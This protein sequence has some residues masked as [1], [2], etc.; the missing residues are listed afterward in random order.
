M[1]GASGVARTAWPPW[2]QAFLNWIAGI[3]HIVTVWLAPVLDPLARFG[4][5]YNLPLGAVFAGLVFGILV[6]LGV[7]WFAERPTT[8]GPGTVRM[9]A[10]WPWEETPAA[11]PAGPATGP[12]AVVKV[13]RKEGVIEIPMSGAGEAPSLPLPRARGFVLVLVGAFAA[14]A[15]LLLYYYGQIF[16]H[17]DHLVALAGTFLYWPLRW[18]G[19]Y[20]V[21]ANALDVPDY[22]FPMYLAAMIAFVAASGLLFGRPHH[23]VGR[24]LF[25]LGLILFYVAMEVFFDAL[26]F[27]VPGREVRDFGLLV[28]T[29][30]GGLFMVVLTFCA[31]YLPKPQLLAA[32]F[33]RDRPA[34]RLFVATGLLAII[35]SIALVVTISELLNVGGVLLPFTLLL[36]VP[37]LA[38]TIFGAIAHPLYYRDV[39]RSRLPPLSEYHP[40]VSIVMPAYN[41]EEWIA[42]TVAAA[43]KAAGHYPGPVEIIVGCD[44]STDRTLELARGAIAKLEHATGVV[45]DLPHGGKS[46]ALNGAL[47]LARH[48]IVLRV[49][50]D[51]HLSETPGFGEMMRHFA[52][53]T[54]G[55][56][57]GALHPYQKNGWT[58][59]LRALEVAWMHYLLRPANMGTRSAEVIDGLFSAFRRADLVELGGWVPW[60]GED[61]EIAMRVQRLGYRIRIEF[62]ALAYEDVPKD[63]D[64]LRRQRVRWG[65]GILMANG[66]HYVALFG[67]TPE[68]CGMS[69]FFWFLLL[70]RSGVR[71]LVYL[72]LA[73][74][75]VVLGV[76]ALAFTAA[77]FLVAILIRA[78]PIGYYL[79]KIGRKDV[80]LWIPFFPIANIIKQSFR[81]EA[82]GTLGPGAAQEYI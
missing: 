36:L 35:L 64:A 74:L 63:Y 12:E 27:T 7:T 28:R 50:A 68:Y 70:M 47:A 82:Y 61:T 14:M 53:P 54:V 78:V 60:N 46:N 2:F 52:D 67:P 80:W 37:L 49:D 24:R 40:S 26:L 45:V 20:T 62:G 17:Y 1:A 73:V 57:Q 10:R 75:I 39:R 66:Q 81:F 21:G 65:R 76:P 3:A 77:L 9:A 56:V 13:Y 59:K 5:T 69:V 33:P 15:L 11:E 43:D 55:G 34:I 31:T 6:F 30:T 25:A 44:G 48:E 22:I 18:P 29:L 79:A 19:I 71:S 38:L 72:Y 58:R 16:N 23:S 32:R 51:T 42:E 8:D 4:R 41:E